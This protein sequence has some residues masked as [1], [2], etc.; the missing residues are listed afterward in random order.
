MNISH[1]SLRSHEYEWWKKL[2]MDRKHSGKDKIQTWEKI[3]I[4]LRNEYI[5]SEYT[6]SMCIRLEKL[7]KNDRSVESYFEEFC[8]MAMRV[9]FVLDSEENIMQFFDG[10]KLSIKM[11]TN[12]LNMWSLEKAY[13]LA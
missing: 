5:N 1:D 2:N 6:L 13:H 10:L 4:K 7:R 12:V 11:K 3:V 8:R 9:C